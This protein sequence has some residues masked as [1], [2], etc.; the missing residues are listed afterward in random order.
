MIPC[1]TELLIAIHCLY[2]HWCRLDWTSASYVDNGN[3]FFFSHLEFLPYSNHPDQ[4]QAFFSWLAWQN[5]LSCMLLLWH[6]A[7]IVPS[8][9]HF[10]PLRHPQTIRPGTFH[11][12]M[13]LHPFPT[14]F[15]IVLCHEVFQSIWGSHVSLPQ[16]ST[17]F[18]SLGTELS[19]QLKVE[20]KNL[21]AIV[22]AFLPSP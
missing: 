17:S 14:L 2:S 10:P 7:F 15:K 3:S 1:S 5:S 18:Y 9:D 12:V 16:L 22:F 11:Q 4:Q 8:F 13:P 6:Q 20:I 19:I 21:H